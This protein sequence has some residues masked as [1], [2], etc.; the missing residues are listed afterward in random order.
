[1]SGDAPIEDLG[2]GWYRTPGGK[3]VQG[4]KAA[5]EKA[6]IEE[7]LDA[8]LEAAGLRGADIDELAIVV[9]SW[10]GR[11]NYRCGHCPHADLN[12]ERMREHVILTHLP[13]PGPQ[14]GPMIIRTDRFGNELAP[15]EG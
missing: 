14:P 10:H 3:K 15:E 7:E 13:A 6:E 4:R 2:G 9:G 8:R 5:E 11:P 12:L 1:M